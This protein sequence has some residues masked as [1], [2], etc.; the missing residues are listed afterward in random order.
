[1]DLW[2][3]P[4]AWELQL[5]LVMAFLIWSQRLL[6]TI[7]LLVSDFA[8]ASGGFCPA[9][10]SEKTNVVRLD[11]KSQA[12]RP[13]NE[14]TLAEVLAFH[15]RTFDVEPLSEVHIAFLEEA[16]RSVE[17]LGHLETIAQSPVRWRLSQNSIWILWADFS[18]IQKNLEF[19]NRHAD[20]TWDEQL[21]QLNSAFNKAQAILAQLQFW[22]TFEKQGYF[23]TPSGHEQ[24]LA[25][26]PANFDKRLTQVNRALGKA[27]SSLP[28]SPSAL[29][30]G[31]QQ[32]PGRTLLGHS[33]RQR[34]LENLQKTL[35]GYIDLLTE[36]RSDPQA[37][38]TDL[39]RLHDSIGALDLFLKDAQLL[40]LLKFSSEQ[41]VFSG[42]KALAQDLQN[43][44]QRLKAM[45]SWFQGPGKWHIERGN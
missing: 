14:Q 39:A 44:L 1:M 2:S 36:I 35:P 43:H 9:V 7:C 30:K 19:A 16:N 6:F 40:D 41:N 22:E 4:G 11:F 27:R 24:I 17:F 5:G 18:L 34:A 42:E 21:R 13:K 28:D 8:F 38:R 25:P 32:F 3:L 45:I 33:Q 31:L 23:L 29:N 15:P 20:Q 37:L 10:L 26:F 12:P